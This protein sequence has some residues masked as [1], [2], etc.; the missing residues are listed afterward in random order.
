M[1]D[2]PQDKK[3]SKPIKVYCKLPNGIQYPL[4][5]G[6]RVRLVGMYGDQRSPLQVSGLPG[7]QSVMGFGV[8][9]VDAEDWEQIVKDHGKSLAHTNG[10][11][12]AAKDDRS[13]AA[14]ARDQ[15]GQKTGL[16]PYDPQAHPEDKSGDGSKKGDPAQE[17]VE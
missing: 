3:V 6:R 9:M 11:I 4:P 15:E 5:D 17:Q 2:A 7:L 10:L 1:A 13:G 12:F 14:Q 16:E 8:S